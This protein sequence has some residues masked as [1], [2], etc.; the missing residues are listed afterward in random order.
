MGIKSSE[1]GK[2]RGRDPESG[3]EGS[4]G[5]KKKKRSHQE[6]SV[7]GRQS[8]RRRKVERGC[9]KASGK[10]GGGTSLLFEF[11]G[12]SSSKALVS[13]CRK[14]ERNLPFPP[15]NYHS[16]TVAANQFTE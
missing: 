9:E 11:L 5:A 14:E 6:L 15:F 8:E 1:G 2:K 4:K 7:R 13:S 10:G 16:L 12:Q 3:C